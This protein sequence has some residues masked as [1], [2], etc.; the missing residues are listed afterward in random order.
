MGSGLVFPSPCKAV[1]H[2]GK[3]YI[4][5]P[6]CRDAQGANQL[7]SPQGRVDSSS[8]SSY[9]LMYQIPS[10]KHGGG[11]VMVCHGMG[12]PKQILKSFMQPCYPFHY[13]WSHIPTKQSSEVSFQA[14]LALVQLLSTGPLNLLA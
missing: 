9:D 13:P 6:M 3:R 12:R 4:Q 10:K 11:S 8:C 14:H 5:V 1:Q 7:I 2:L